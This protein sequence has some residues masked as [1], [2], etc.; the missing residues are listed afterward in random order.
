MVDLPNLD[1]QTWRRH[2]HNRPFLVLW[3]AAS[4]L[5]QAMNSMRNITRMNWML[6][7][8]ETEW[9]L[10]KKQDSAHMV[11]EMLVVSTETG[12]I[13]TYEISV[14]RSIVKNIVG[15]TKLSTY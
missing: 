14:T 1:V 10:I 6:I 15:K 3:I 12:Y 2:K 7:K 9:V 13:S 8:K 11:A 4:D 5:R